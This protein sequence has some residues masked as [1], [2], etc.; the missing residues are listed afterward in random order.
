MHSHGPSC[1]SGPITR[2]RGWWSDS[3]VDDLESLTP[4]RSDNETTARE[5]APIR[6]A[7]VERVRRE[8]AAGVYDTPEKFEMALD[9]LQRRL[10]AE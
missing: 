7:L 10:E 1:L 5:E 6:T 8:I 2:E 3:E 4:F 9:R